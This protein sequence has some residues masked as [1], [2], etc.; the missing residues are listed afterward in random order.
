MGTEA[1]DL[2]GFHSGFCGG[3]WGISPNISNNGDMNGL[4][5]FM[6]IT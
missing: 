4:L 1:V 3:E 6:V 5:P 2:M